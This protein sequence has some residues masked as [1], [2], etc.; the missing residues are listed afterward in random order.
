MNNPL[1]KNKVKMIPVCIRVP[2]HIIHNIDKYVDGVR[3]RS[4]AHLITTVLKDYIEQLDQV[5]G[6]PDGTEDRDMDFFKR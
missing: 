3:F 1:W 2:D 5:D 6:D 4:R